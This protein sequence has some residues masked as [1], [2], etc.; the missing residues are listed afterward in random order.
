VMGR[1]VLAVSSGLCLSA[2]AALLVLK[3]TSAPT[4]RMWMRP[5]SG[6]G[7]HRAEAHDRK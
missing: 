3:A 2:L 5:L 6:E 7:G 1:D 4:R